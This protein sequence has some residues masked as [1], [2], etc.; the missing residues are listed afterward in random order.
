[1]E[2]VLLTKAP[3]NVPTV[4]D[5]RSKKTMCLRINT[6][7]RCVYMKTLGGPAEGPRVDGELSPLRDRARTDATTPDFVRKLVVSRL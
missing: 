6:S 3:K 2:Y 1:M 5:H 4:V 7:A